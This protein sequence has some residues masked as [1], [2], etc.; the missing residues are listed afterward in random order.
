MLLQECGLFAVRPNLNK[1]GVLTV[2]SVKNGVPDYSRAYCHSEPD[3]VIVLE[4]AKPHIK[5]ASVRLINAGGNKFPCA[6]AVG[7]ISAVNGVPDNMR[8][9]APITFDPRG[10]TPTTFWIK[11]GGYEY[12]WISPR[13]VV[14]QGT[15]IWLVECGE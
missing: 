10:K 13:T 12:P 2:H 4:Q 11:N 8:A 1:P 7:I 9:V 14:L 5:E 15:K 3:D 6:S